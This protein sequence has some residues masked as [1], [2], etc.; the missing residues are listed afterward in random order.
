M[1]YSIYSLIRNA[2]SYHEGWQQAWRSPDPKPTYEVVIVGG[3]GHGLATAYYLASEC[4]VRNVAV[5][6]KGWLG[7]GNTGRNTT[8]VR[9]N[10]LW[11]ESAAIYDHSVKLWHGL[12][13]QLN[14][15]VMFSPRGLLHLAHSVHDMQEIGRRGNSNFLNGIDAEYLTPEQ[16]KEMVPFIN[17]SCRYPVMG[18]LLQ[19]RGGV[20]RHDAVAWGYA[21]AADALGVDI[22]QNCEVTGFEIDNGTV[23]A[24]RTTRGDIGANKVGCVVAGHC[25]V[26]AEMAGFRLPIE[27]FPLQALGSEPIKP[28]I[29]CVVMSNGV[30]AYISQ[31]E[32]GA[33]VLGASS[34]AYS[35]YS[36]RGGFNVIE[37]TIGAI[38]ELYPIFSRMCMLRQWGGIVDVTVDR[39]PLI[40]K[41]PVKNLYVN[42]GWGTG[43]FKATPGSGHVFAHS[44]AGTDM[45]PI[46]DP[47][48]IDRFNTGA[49]VDEGA[50]AAVA[51]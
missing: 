24:V 42:C 10:Y 27:S 1:K 4:G 36:Q 9:S 7:G 40:S 39:S 5:I 8:I 21:R 3:G 6:E 44:I 32:R 31:S 20:A 25:S 11:D 17:L 45:H 41:T 50:A 2:F 12:S 34:D 47:F 22:I 23:K 13:Q 26:L 14:Y 43:G 37:D 19:R 46:A 49:L 48:S 29:D 33:L 18:A 38:V 28:I 35:S 16:V 15:N 30:H 51:H